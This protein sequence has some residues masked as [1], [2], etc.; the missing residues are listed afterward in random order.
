M[1]ILILFLCKL[2]ISIYFL[3]AWDTVCRRSCCSRKQ[4]PLHCGNCIQCQNRR[5]VT[6]YNGLYLCSWS[7]STKPKAPARVNWFQRQ[8]LSTWFVKSGSQLCALCLFT[9]KGAFGVSI[10]FYFCTKG[11]ITDCSFQPCCFKEELEELY[12]KTDQSQKATLLPQ[13]W[14][15]RRQVFTWTFHIC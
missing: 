7:A 3:Q 8:W 9:S 14:Q 6:G 2:L 4:L 15:E 13:I 5:W 11:M 1:I 12:K 10:W